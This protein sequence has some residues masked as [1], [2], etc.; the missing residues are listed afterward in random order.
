MKTYGVV[1]R[2]E[3]E[4]GSH[5]TIQRELNGMYIIV[6]HWHVMNVTRAYL[7][8]NLKDVK[9]LWDVL[10]DTTMK[11]TRVLVNQPC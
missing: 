11:I 3:F 7:K 10:K 1:I 5:A 8:S 4:N 6:I 9:Y 2:M